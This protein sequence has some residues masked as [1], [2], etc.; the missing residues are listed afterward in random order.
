M[1]YDYNSIRIREELNQVRKCIFNNFYTTIPYA[2]ILVS[3]SII[4]DIILK[5]NYSDIQNNIE[6]NQGL[7]E[8]ISY[9][10][11]FEKVVGDEQHI[12]ETDYDENITE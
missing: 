9:M 1:F 6:N 11:S 5:I 10:L 7:R 2:K 12:M 3:L 4:D 8:N